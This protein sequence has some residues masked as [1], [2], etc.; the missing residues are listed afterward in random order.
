VKISVIIPVFNEADQIAER[1]QFVLLNGGSK[2]AEVIVVDGL[3]TD[4]T[5]SIAAKAGAKVLLCEER[6]RAAQMNRGAREATGTVLYFV[7]AD[8]KLVGSF[9]E[10]IEGALKHS[11]AGCYRYVFDSNRFILK[12]NAW[13]TRFDRIMCRGGDQ[14]LYVRKEVFDQLNGFDEYYSIMEDYDFILRLREKFRFYIIPKNVRVSARKYDTN[15]WLQV[16]RANFIVFMMFFQKR[17]PNEMKARYRQ[18]LNYR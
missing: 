11:D 7:H 1:I 2:V 18:L 5:V 4:E 6:S 12:I 9:A 8:V 3:S 13:F 15:S 17:P 14:T 16:Q 10:D